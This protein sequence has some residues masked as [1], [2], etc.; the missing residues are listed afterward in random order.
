MGDGKFEYVCPPS[1]AVGL[2]SAS[3]L[4]WCEPDSLQKDL[5]DIRLNPRVLLELMHV[6]SISELGC[7]GLASFWNSQCVKYF[8]KD[9]GDFT[10]TEARQCLG[11][12]LNCVNLK[13]H[14]I[15]YLNFIGLNPQFSLQVLKRFQEQKVSCLVVAEAKIHQDLL[16]LCFR[17]RNSSVVRISEN[18]KDILFRGC[19]LK[20]SLVMQS[21]RELIS[22]SVDFNQDE[23]T[24]DFKFMSFS[25]SN[26]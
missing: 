21:H 14:G 6:F 1:D 10:F 17:H 22:L 8:S 4:D 16:D 7:D 24:Q 3:D 5:Q 2:D 26:H 23:V 25:V 20:T 18:S 15:V 12:I 11:S 9:R 13:S 19:G